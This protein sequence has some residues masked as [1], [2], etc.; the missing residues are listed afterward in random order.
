[1]AEAQYKLGLYTE[2]GL[3]GE[4]RSLLQ[5]RVLYRMAAEQGD[6]DAQKAL[7]RLNKRWF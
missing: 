4:P 5:A 3:G 1:M 2:R 6:E 7:E